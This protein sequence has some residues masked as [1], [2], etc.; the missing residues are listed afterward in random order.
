MAVEQIA[1]DS[2][3]SSLDGSNA[4]HHEDEPSRASQP[5]GVSCSKWVEVGEVAA[6]TPNSATLALRALSH[7]QYEAMESMGG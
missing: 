4:A 6:Y 2:K 7:Q 5:E 3:W 1:H